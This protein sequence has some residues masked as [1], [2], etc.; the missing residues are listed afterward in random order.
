LAFHVAI[1]YDS[2]LQALPESFRALGRHVVLDGTVDEMAAPAR[3]R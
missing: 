3:F 1:A 2:L